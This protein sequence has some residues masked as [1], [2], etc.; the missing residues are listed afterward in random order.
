MVM[1]RFNGHWN[2]YLL[3]DT[4]THSISTSDLH[5]TVMTKFNSKVSAALALVL[6]A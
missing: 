3:M 4:T 6:R 2:P 1:G 5:I